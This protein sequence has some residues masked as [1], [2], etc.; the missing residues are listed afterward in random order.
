M[1]TIR[2]IFTAYAP[3][4]L[5]RFPHLPMAH[6]KTLSAILHCPS[7][8]DGHR[9]SQCQGCG[10]QHRVQHACGNRHWPQCQPQKTPQW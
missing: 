7:G 8:P 6:Q 3:E 9:L 10:G 5:A 1:T 4:D 2:D